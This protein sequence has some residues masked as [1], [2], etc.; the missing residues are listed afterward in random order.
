MYDTKRSGFAMIM[1]IFVVVLVALGGA[2]ILSKASKGTKMLGDNYIHTQAELLALSATEFAIM[3]IQ[4]M[5]NDLD[6][7][8]TN[9]LRDINID[10]QDSFGVSAYNVDVNLSYSFQDTKGVVDMGCGDDRTIAINN[11]QG[12]MARIDVTVTDVKLA[13]EQIRVFKRSFQKL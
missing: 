10:V 9:C 3:N 5:V 13:P 11:T 2:M 8:I 12:N 6:N 7:N 4:D 1:A